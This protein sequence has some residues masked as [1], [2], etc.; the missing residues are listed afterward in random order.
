[1][2]CI[3]KELSHDCKKGLVPIYS[4]FRDALSHTHAHLGRKRPSRLKFNVYHAH[5]G[6]CDTVFMVCLS[7]NVMVLSHQMGR[8]V[9]HIRGP[10]LDGMYPLLGGSFSIGSFLYII[11]YIKNCTKHT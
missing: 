5:L 3:E 7:P 9:W 10:S 6:L 1:M 11:N 2:S 8:C 4:F